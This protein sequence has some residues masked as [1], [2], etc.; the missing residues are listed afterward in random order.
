[1]A[2][3]SAWSR[4]RGTDGVSR[5]KQGLLA[6]LEWRGFAPADQLKLVE[7]GLNTVDELNILREVDF[8]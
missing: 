5:R 3:L 7:D 8:N 4:K 2:E 6:E 1:M